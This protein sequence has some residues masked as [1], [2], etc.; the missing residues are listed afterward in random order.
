MSEFSDKAVSLQTEVMLMSWAETNS[1]GRTVTFL[2]PEDGDSHPFREDKVKNGKSSGQRYMMVLVKI[3]D[4]ERPV[5]KTPAQI[6]A[7]LCKDTMFQ[8]FLN[9]RS[10]VTIDSEESARALILEGCGINSRAKLDTSMSARAAWEA[11]FYRPWLKY[12]EA[13]ERRISGG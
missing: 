2:L 8:E 1:R 12:R 3:G 7:T 10:F 6:C 5:E 11:Q 13:M 4:D 9:D